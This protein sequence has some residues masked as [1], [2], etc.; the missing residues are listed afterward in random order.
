MS[1]VHT[2]LG[3]PSRI[4]VVV[5]RSIHCQSQAYHGGVT[6]TSQRPHGGVGGGIAGSP[7]GE[8]RV[9]LFTHNKHK[10]KHKH[11]IKTSIQ[12]TGI[13]LHRAAT[14]A[15]A[16]APAGP[17]PPSPGAAAP[18]AAA[19]R[20]PGCM[21]PLTPAAGVVAAAGGGPSAVVVAMRAAVAWSCV[22]GAWACCGVWECRIIMCVRE[23]SATHSIKSTTHQIATHSGD[24]HTG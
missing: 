12:P 2:G 9:G 19:V 18:A 20:P 23:S 22:C 13:P 16:A 8:D 1:V 4:K 15:G 17:A 7:Y 11:E 14:A 5:N 21:W 10:H 3:T 6:G 24:T